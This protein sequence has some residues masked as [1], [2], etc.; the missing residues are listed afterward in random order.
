MGRYGP[1]VECFRGVSATRICPLPG[2]GAFADSIRA[3]GAGARRRSVAHPPP[4]RSADP[5]ARDG[6]GQRGRQEAGGGQDQ[7]G[8]GVAVFAPGDL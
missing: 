3:W 4:A 8:L 1:A 7:G 6:R 2:S 5:S